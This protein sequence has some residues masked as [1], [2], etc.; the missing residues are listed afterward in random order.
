MGANKQAV[1][2]IGDNTDMYAQAYFAYDS[3]KSGGFTVS[4]LRFGKAPI[5]SS[6]LVN[7]A[8]FVA[9]HKAAYVQLYDV[10]EGIKDG[11][12]FLLNS[13]W[14]TLEDMERE[15]PGRMKRTIARKGLK[16]YNVDA[17]KLAMSLGLGGR[18]NMITQTAYFKLP[19]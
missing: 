6:Y 4:H 10:L 3:K 15:L 5:K 13:P 14:E 16:F 12:T 17:V 11:G 1:K 8:D 19:T 2:I 7:Q 9:C 18:I